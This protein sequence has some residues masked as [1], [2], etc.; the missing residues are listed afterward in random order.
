M[1]VESGNQKKWAKHKITPYLNIFF[2]N[3]W[4]FLM[5]LQLFAVLP[6]CSTLKKHQKLRGKK[7]KF[8]LNSTLQNRYW[9]SWSSNRLSSL[10]L[11]NTYNTQLTYFWKTLQILKDWIAFPFV[12]IYVCATFYQVFSLKYMLDSCIHFELLKMYF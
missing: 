9:A 4:P 12:N 2:L 5:L 3:F 11:P 10:G 1:L 8:L 6:V 7:G